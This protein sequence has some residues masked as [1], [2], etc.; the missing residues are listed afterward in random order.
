MSE[1]DPWQCYE[2]SVES[3]DWI[4]LGAEIIPLPPNRCQDL[5]PD[6][7]V[8]GLSKDPTPYEMPIFVIDQLSTTRGGR[9]RVTIYKAQAPAT[10]ATRDLIDLK[11]KWR[12]AP[13]PIP[14]EPEEPV[15]LSRYKR[16]PVI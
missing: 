7:V 5:I 2:P 16:K 15:I 4:V 3:G 8:K 12:P 9:K 11:E 10:R 14:D 6:W 13:P 1:K